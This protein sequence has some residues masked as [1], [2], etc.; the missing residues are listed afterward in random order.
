MPAATAVKPD[1]T[2]RGAVEPAREAAL[3]VAEGDAVGEHLG[4]EMVEERLATH[5]FACTAPAYRGWR[6]AV[7]VSRVAR[8]KAV[9]VCEANLVPGDGALLSP[10]WVPYAARLAPGDLG[11]GDVT[12]FVED[13]PLLEPGFEATGDE[14]VDAV[15]LWELGLGRPRVLS[16][17]GRDVAAQRWYD[18]EN[19]PSAP[20]ATKAPMPCSSCGF[21]VP[22]AGALRS[23]FGVCAN[24][25]SPSDG[26]VVSLDH[27]CGAHSEVDLEA[28]APERVSPPILDD[29]EL[30][31]T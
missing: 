1:S 31:P 15:A 6:W 14:D 9:T 19:G 25:W 24:A 16:A 3:A 2:L 30:D 22:M 23:V 12:P 11:P 8:S 28:P 21:L 17:E 18:G 10:E 7:S 4:M 5:Y 20:V 13:D 29:F 26:R 27:G